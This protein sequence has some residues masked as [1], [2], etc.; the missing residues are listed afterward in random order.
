[1]PTQT[2][3]S[4][5]LVAS[6]ALTA[7]L[8]IPYVLE[9]FVRIGIPQ[10]LMN[11][12]TG[13]PDD[14]APWAQ[15]AARAHLNAVENLAVFAPL[16]LLALQQGLG[17]TALAGGAAAVYFWARLVHFVCYSAGVPVVR[18]LAFVAGFGAQAA[19]VVALLGRAS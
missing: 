18:T 2:N 12:K 14:R 10:S 19:L 11:P 13:G 7:S 9:R 17:A 6:L 3:T 8:W 4:F 16:A 5:W 1:M 15:R